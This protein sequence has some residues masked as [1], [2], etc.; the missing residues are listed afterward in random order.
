[1]ILLVAKRA[2]S[3]VAEVLAEYADNYITY[4]LLLTCIPP[5][6]SYIS[7]LVER[8]QFHWPKSNILYARLRNGGL[9]C[10]N[11]L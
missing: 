3:Q 2:E 11:A 6:L 1:M 10:M 8:M 5:E 7:N 4:Y 9:N